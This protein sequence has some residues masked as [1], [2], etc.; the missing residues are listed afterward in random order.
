MSKLAEIEVILFVAGKK[1]LLARQIADL[2]FFTPNRCGA[3]FRKFGPKNIQEAHRYQSVLWDS[4]L[5]T[6]KGTTLRFY[7]TILE[8]LWTK[9]CLGPFL[10]T[11]SII[12]YKQTDHLRGEVDDI[13]GVNSS[14]PLP[15]YCHLTWSAKMEKEVLN[16]LYVT[17][18]YFWIIWGSIIWSGIAKGWG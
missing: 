15:N 9:A 3:K 12:A 1:E 11:L 10:E 17:T 8:R 7:E 5:Q 2:L 4:F 6:D 16:N 18:K 14:K 13:R